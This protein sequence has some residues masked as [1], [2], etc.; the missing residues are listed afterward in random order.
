MSLQIEK[1]ETENRELQLVVRVDESRVEK[2]MQAVAKRYAKNLRI[3]GFRPGKAPFHVVRNWVGKEALRAEAVDSLTQDV[4]QEATQQAEA[5]P[6]APG[7]LTD[8]EMDPVV[9]HI[10]VPLQ[11]TVDLGEY[12]DVRIDVPAV[13]V[14]DQQV[15]EALEAV[16]DKHA[17]LEPAD[18]PAQEG[19][20]VIADLKGEQDG[21][22]LID[23]QGAELLLDPE[24]LFRETPFVENVVGMSAGEEKSF[25]INTAGE[26][27]EPTMMTYTVKV[28]EVKSRYVP[29]L[30]DDLAKEEGDLETLLEL[31][32]ETRKKLTEEAQRKADA[33]YANQ[34]FEKILEGATVS[35][36][37]AAV[38][39]E[40]DQQIQEIEQR[41]KQQGWGLEDY[42]KLQAKSL[43]DMREDLRPEATERLVRGQVTYALVEAE[44]LVMEED[45]LDRQ[46]EQRLGEMDGITDELAGQLRDLYRSDQGRMMMANDV[47][48]SKFTDRLMQIG[49]GDAPDLAELSDEE[50]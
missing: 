12:R 8:I 31:R 29:P 3:P 9:F 23:R 48:M 20:V 44:R 13:K 40:I 10:T 27:E 15:D 45:E 28:H 17:L 43:E 21:E 1:Q 37:P 39:Y 11:P 19:D 46:I 50:E 38:E 24:K 49:R 4:Y 16:Q 42:L 33:E 34:V 14:T 36:P 7:S 32:I 25:E 18:R 2:A 5:I 22:V 26:D 47:I 35:Y 6:Y 41:F 30:N